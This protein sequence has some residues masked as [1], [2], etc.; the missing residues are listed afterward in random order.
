MMQISFIDG[1][2]FKEKNIQVKS[3]F[4]QNSLAK[5][6]SDTYQQQGFTVNTVK[7]GNSTIIDIEKNKG[8]A[9]MF[10]GKEQTITVEYKMTGDVLTMNFSNGAWLGKLI[11]IGFGVI[12]CY[13]PTVMSIIGVVNQTKLYKGIVEIAEKAAN[14]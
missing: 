12:L 7:K 10:F 1:V 14:A 11:G 13:V 8:G 9:A 6:L 5:A 3:G 2:F 4:D